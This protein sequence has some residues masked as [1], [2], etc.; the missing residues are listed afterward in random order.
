ME[1]ITGL[2]ADIAL[3][4]ASIAMGSTTI[5]AEALSAALSSVG[6]SAL[7]TLAY[8]ASKALY[9]GEKSSLGGA[10]DELVKKAT[11]SNNLGEFV[12]SLNLMGESS[13]ENALKVSELEVN[14]QKLR[15][16]TG[17]QSI[18]IDN[19]NAKLAQ[20]GDKTALAAELQ[21]SLGG[22]I[23][24]SKTNFTDLNSVLELSKQTTGELTLHTG[25]LG[26]EFEKAGY[27]I[28]PVTGVIAKLEES[29]NAVDGA[30][31]KSSDGFNTLA[32]AE[33]YLANNAKAGN[34]QFIEYK[35]G[36]YQVTSGGFDAADSAKKLG[37]ETQKAAEAGKLCWR[38]KSRPMSSRLP[39]ANW[40]TSA[41]RSTCK[42]AWTC[43][44]HRSKPT[45]RA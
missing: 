41:I 44:C 36:L 35:D 43:R 9:N 38:P 1:Y 40:Q 30:A 23:D 22:K 27:K 12:Y 5:S 33:Q 17:D 10:I 11:G 8:D 26:D 39:W 7:I 25:T 18:T 29:L 42:P 2:K 31:K 34:A 37:E 19:Y 4:N 45:P 16:A 6:W 13:K 3:L 28:D 32:A 14:V 15:N 20:F 24:I 21:N